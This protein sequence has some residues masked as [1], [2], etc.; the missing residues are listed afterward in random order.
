MTKGDTVKI[1]RGP[2][3]GMEIT[4]HRRDVANLAWY[5][6]LVG[7]MQMWHKSGAT[8][9]LDGLVL[10]YEYELAVERKRKVVKRGD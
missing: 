3:S 4:L 2:L 6:Q 7:G 9:E 8:A 5:G 1:H 10:V